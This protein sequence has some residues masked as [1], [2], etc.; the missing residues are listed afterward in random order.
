MDYMV[1][2][3]QPW[4]LYW[5]VP[6]ILG[7]VILRLKLVK[8]PVYRYSLASYLNLH[9]MTSAHWYPKLFFLIRLF[10][11][12]IL[13]FLIAKPQLVDTRSSVRVEGIDIMLVLDVSGSMSFQDYEDDRRSR[14]E[15]AK[16]E[17]IRFIQKRANDAI[18]VVIF[19]KDVM[20]RAPLTLDK[21][22]LKQVVGALEIGIIDPDGTL[23][24]TAIL[25]AAN[26]LKQS[27]ATSKVMIL[28]TDGTPSEGDADPALALEIAQKLGIK[29]YTVGI[30]SDEDQYFMHPL[31]GMVPKPKVNKALLQKI[32]RQTGGTFFLA[33]SSQDM[34]VIYDTIDSLERT[35]QD[36]SVFSKYYD[37]FIPFVWMLLLVL[38][39]Q[40]I[41]ASFIW[42]G[43]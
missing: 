20:S 17:A 15:V 8:T 25:T 1:R 39:I 28:L 19:G 38:L 9:G 22:I 7:A 5:L 14:L 40:L 13:A 2:L 30:G 37:I 42:F 26:R 41:C 6:C 4:V 33:R 35:V 27:K 43:V 18:G 10:V 31:Y 3:G 24:S 23:L 21:S 12:S 11:L 16:D 32:A 34:R 36:A 29:I